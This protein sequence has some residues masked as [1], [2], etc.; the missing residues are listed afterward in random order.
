MNKQDSSGREK[1]QHRGKFT[2]GLLNRG[3]IL[4]ALNIKPGQTVM[5]A[6][7]GNGYMSKLFSD[8]VSESGKVIALDP[9]QYSIELLGKETAGTNIQAIEGDI[10]RTT[11]LEPSSIDLIYISA[12]IHGFSKK[13]MQD[14]FQEVKRLLK[15]GAILAIVEIEKKETPFGPPM[16]LR[17]SPEELKAIVP[18]VSVD[19]IQ[20]GEY[21][22][23]QVFQNQ[24]SER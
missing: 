12:V 2:E 17:Y 1:H 8:K 3:A 20:A 11:R 22:Y 7:C 21:F 13:Q 24:V 6:G 15:P 14:F 19:T 23:M 9:D 4:N 5:D 18:L 16:E 10:T